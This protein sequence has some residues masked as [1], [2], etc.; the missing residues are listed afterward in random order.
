MVPLLVKT[1]AVKMIEKI[2]ISIKK[3]ME[4]IKKKFEGNDDYEN[5]FEG[6]EFPNIYEYHRFCIIG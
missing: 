2:A 5:V 1:Q 4:S 6:P 3:V